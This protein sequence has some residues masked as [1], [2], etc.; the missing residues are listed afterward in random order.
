MHPPFLAKRLYQESGSM[1]QIRIFPENVCGVPR[2]AAQIRATVNHEGIAGPITIA[3]APAS[4][5]SVSLSF[6]TTSGVQREREDSI[7][8]L[9]A[10]IQNQSI[11][12]PISTA[13]ID[14]KS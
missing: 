12:P 14:R 1:R 8:G 10:P 13:M 9:C 6:R 4:F 3:A 7:V 2:L 5:R 11:P